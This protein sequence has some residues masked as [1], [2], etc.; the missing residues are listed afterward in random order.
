MVGARSPGV[1]TRP[2]GESRPRRRGD[3]RRFLRLLWMTDFADPRRAR[4]LHERPLYLFLARRGSVPSRELE[5]KSVLDRGSRVRYADAKALRAAIMQCVR[6]I[7]PT[8]RY[9]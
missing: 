2:T 8:A 3:D 6:T 1:P 4:M 9:R 5:L 7:L